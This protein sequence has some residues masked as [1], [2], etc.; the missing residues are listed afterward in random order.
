MQSR[1]G[2][3]THR[4]FLRR[5]SDI[6]S[7]AWPILL[8]QLAVIA[9]GVIDTAMTARYSAA[10]L[11]ALAI[12]ASVYISV[13]VSLN[14]T[15]QALSPI[16]GQ[17]FGARRYAEI[18]A[19]LRQGAWL[20]LFLTLA[21][22]IVLLYPAPLLDLAQASP[23][24]R[25]K[26]ERYLLILTLALPASLGFRVYASLNNAIGRPKMVMAIQLGMLSL[27]VPLNALFI[28]GGLGLPA[29]GGPGCAVATALSAWLALLTGLFLLRSR[30]FYRDFAI[31]SKRLRIN[32]KDQLALL[33]LGIPIGM[34]Y[35]I[36]V[37]AYT[38]MALFIAR[39][40]ETVLAAHQ[41]TANFGTVLYMLPLSIASATGVLTAQA[42]GGKQL[43][44]ARQIGNAGIAL[45]ALL[46]CL[47]GMLVWLAR[48][49]IIAA[50]TSNPAV[51]AAARPLFLF[52]AFYQLFDA[53]QVST[54]FV[55]RAY[56]IALVPTMLYAIGLWGAGLGGGI[57][58]GLDPFDLQLFGGL[59][60]SG[61]WLANSF[62]LAL[63][64][65]SLLWYL[66][67]VQARFETTTAD[68]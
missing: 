24:M 49:A 45:A 53:I 36:E 40:G 8:G 34:S 26:V 9:N 10:D 22:C 12:G 66:R 30:P 63:V 68:D 2:H 19:Q 29:M 39:L 17:L 13:F 62:S 4:Q 57:L 14:G 61:F 5:F 31:F 56:K 15:L 27:K 38:F 64:G 48:D 25:E 55:L 47:M 60:A 43:G 65:L 28:F 67:R 32:W 6:S 1:S 7:L 44:Q 50:Y 20:A 58:L 3:G 42:I 46:S 18:G 21:G 33:K 23:A 59:G 41:V 51:A 11:A 52:I 16:I 54:A 35:L 37:T